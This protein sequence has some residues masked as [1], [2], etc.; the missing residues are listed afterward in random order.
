MIG[1]TGR[2]PGARDVEQYW[3]N[4]AGGVESISK[5]SD[6]E[7]AA[8]G[9]DVAELKSV[10]G[11]VP[12][13]GVMA[14]ADLFDAG[15]FGFSGTEAAVIDPQQRLF[16]EAS[17]ELLESAGYDPEA[18]EGLIG[19]YAGMGG[20][21]YYLHY[22]H[23]RKDVTRLVGDRVV[24]LGND[25][26]FLATR[27]AYKLNLKGPA[28]NINTACSTS[29]V[30][31]CQACQELMSFQ[32]DLA[33]AG[34]VSINFPQKA[35]VYYQ[36]GGVFSPD[37]HCRPFDAQ[38]AG[39]VSS[40][41]LG[42]VLLKRLSEAIAD[43]DQIHAVIRGFG[44][45][46]DGSGKVGFT[47][48]SVD[49]QSEAILTAQSMAGFDPATITYLEAHGTAT[50]L[51]DPIEI[52]ALTQAFRFET[53]AKNFCAI[54]SVKG[55]IGHT[56]TAA[57]IAGLL[58]TILALRNQQLPPTINY[59][60]PNPKID[61]ADS[62]FFVNT[63]LTDWKPAGPR[64]AGVSSF[65]LGGTNAH[66]VL[67]EAPALEPSAPPRG[68]QV[69]VLSAKSSAALDTA[70][71]NLLAHLKEHPEINLADAAYTLQVG[72]RHFAHRRS[73]VCRDVPD[74]IRTIEKR[75]P[76]RIATY[77]RDLDA[78]APAVVF[79]FPGQGSQYVGMGA[80][81][82]RD[83]PV[84]KEEMD[85]CAVILKPALDGL[86]LR[87]ILYPA[88]DKTKEAEEL[89]I[90]T[91]IT[92]PALFAIEYALAKLWMSW[93]VQ[94]AALTGHS[95]GEYVAA[96]LAG[97]FSLEE[98]LALVAQRG[99]LIQA[100]PRGSMMAVSMTEAELK[101]ILPPN[102]SI[103]GVN[104]PMQCVVSGTTED[105]TAFEATLKAAGKPGRPLHTSHAFHSAMMDPVVA[106]FAECVRRAKRSEP[107][108]PFLSNLTGKWI[109]PAEAIDP[110]YWARHLRQA[111]RFADGVKELLKN[112]NAVFLEVGPGTTL[113]SLTKFQANKADNRAILSSLR[114]AK[115]ELPD[116]TAMMAALGQLWQRG[117]KPDWSAIHG[118][119]KRH[120]VILPGH[121]LQRQRHWIERAAQPA[122]VPVPVAVIPAPAPVAAA[123]QPQAASTAVAPKGEIEQSL[124]EIWKQLLGLSEVRIDDNFFDL[125]GDS[126]LL[127]RLQLLVQ[128]KF[129][130]TLA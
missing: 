82:Y 50:P 53:E 96:C 2:F 64:R 33:L 95:L 130:V 124:T 111:V 10:P 114:H 17:W 116:L 37:G 94:P 102:L 97:V 15:F 65:G 5:F 47:A 84:F 107:T 106:T 86:D 52:A 100:L 46:N 6:S 110:Q 51:G 43:G 44:R 39:T 28:L 66:V 38:A 128:E 14:D 108:I 9:H 23:G 115:E 91:R 85:R 58:K 81:L 129:H 36:E 74:A 98:A 27:V 55:N 42:I 68:E 77:E 1:L 75:D 123:P 78:D 62:P 122:P 60:A 112:P 31:V 41:G 99:K 113:G 61:F 120:R 29:L 104:G 18:Y 54:G 57:G 80:D 4:I 79:M 71:A 73:V 22:L 92:Q 89:L 70:T 69:L 59:T 24:S 93:G 125:G 26:D 25:K 76:K 49:G 87:D 121:P 48:P 21:G 101:T 105:I 63:Q 127:M 16:L 40:D 119:L 126:L 90:Q 45:N 7:L 72:R 20:N 56:N 88:A 11:F 117:I 103:A 13:R 35:G 109:T 83:Q 67:E 8:A 118:G 32:C 34:G 3:R 30:T 19:V 12:A